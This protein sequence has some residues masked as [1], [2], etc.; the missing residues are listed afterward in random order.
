MSTPPI[1]SM[2]MYDCVTPPLTDGSYRI[3]VNT[4]VTYDGGSPAL[5][6]NSGYFDIEGP[7]FTLP[8]TDVGGVYPPRNGHGGF[9]EFIPQIAIS[10]RTLPWERRLSVDLSKF[11]TPKSRSNPLTPQPNPFPEAG[12]FAPTPWLALLLLAE[13]E[14]TL[15]QNVQLKSIMPADCYA[16]LDVP[17]GI[18]C[19]SI[20]VEA[21]LL[22]S[23]LP[24]LDE[25][26][27]LTHVRQVN[28]DDKELN[29]ASSTGFYAIVTSNRL[30]SPNAKYR[31]CLVSLEERTD[32]VK[33]DPPPVAVP[34]FLGVVG[35]VIL[36]QPNL[37]HDNPPEAD[38][39][40]PF[41][42]HAPVAEFNAKQGFNKAFDT[43]VIT[44]SAILETVADRNVSDAIDVVVGPE[45]HFYIETKQ[46]VLLHSWTFECTGTGT[47]RDYVQRIN[48]STL[49]TVEE[50]GHPP[51]IDTGHIPIKIVD[52]AGEPEDV[53][54]RGPLVPV[55]LTRDP[56]TYH[57]ADQCR[58]VT[59]ETGAEDISYAAAFECG[60]LLAAADPRLAQEL[61]RWR[62]ESYRQSVRLDSLLQIQA[63]IPL[64]Q[65][66][67]I[68][69]PVASVVAYNAAKGVI[70]GVDQVADTYGL[71][72][73]GR[74][75]GM[76]PSELQQAWG[77]ASIDEATAILGGEPGA[78]GTVVSAPAQTVRNATTLAQVVGDTASLDRL[79]SARD[80]ALNAVQ[81][82]LGI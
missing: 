61:M 63:A 51:V 25:L 19:D 6:A 68:H 40:H 24:S 47:F 3:D 79:Q 50:T 64:D 67:E 45:F 62:R 39:E 59:P 41:L 53:W 43:T 55:P 76:N 71:N 26:S 14:Y 42:G 17:D 54:Y 80:L 73:A 32:L 65:Q 75:P 49:G 10:R 82:K 16:N 18:V 81:Q 13:G 35:N 46:L 66:L 70:T 69:K 28:V 34:Y 4:D 52:R 57:S 44:R 38:N 2:Y 48:V 74:A 37:V 7:R 58:R 8:A 22:Q 5:D 20:E 1:G 9:D 78:I 30:P 29:A 77:L 33:A 56:L 11:G 31:A 36:D 23:I 60:R 21:N 72:A 15:H 12:E 27:L